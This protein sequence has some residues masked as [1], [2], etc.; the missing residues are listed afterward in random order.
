MTSA[1]SATIARI[2]ARRHRLC[3]D[4]LPG[5]LQLRK[6]EGVS[7]LAEPLHSQPPG[8]VHDRRLEQGELGDVTPDVRPVR[9]EASSLPGRVENAIRARVRAGPGDPLPV[10]GVARRIA[11]DEKVEEVLGAATPVDTEA[12]REKRRCQQA[13]AV[14]H[15]PLALELAHPRVDDGNAGPAGPPGIESILVVAPAPTTRT[16]VVDLKSRERSEQLQTEVTPAELSQELAALRALAHTLGDLEG[17]DAPEPEIRREPRGRVQRELVP[18]C[19]VLR[20]TGL[21]EPGKPPPSGRLAALGK[22]G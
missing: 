18:S 2:L 8:L 3:G 19:L 17:G 9:I 21:E 6:R 14:R 1:I 22:L 4:D 7:E 10:R 16:V 20:Q 11:V 12:L 13:N 5:A 15:P